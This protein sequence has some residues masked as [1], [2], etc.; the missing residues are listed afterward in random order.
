ML[1]DAK[2]MVRDWIESEQCSNYEKRC[3]LDDSLI[4]IGR[5][6]M[7]D[8]FGTIHFRRKKDPELSAN[9]HRESKTFHLATIFDDDLIRLRTLMTCL[10][11]DMMQTFCEKVGIPLKVEGPKKK[12]SDI[13]D[14]RQWR[15]SHLQYTVKEVFSEVSGFMT[16][17][18][19]VNFVTDQELEWLVSQA[20]IDDKVGDFTSKKRLHWKRS[21]RTARKL[22]ATLSLMS[23]DHDGKYQ[24]K[25][26]RSLSQE[27]TG[28]ENAG[29][30]EESQEEDIS[31]SDLGQQL[32]LWRR[33]RVDK[34]CRKP[35]R[36]AFKSVGLEECIVNKT[37]RERVYEVEI[38]RAAFLILM[39]DVYPV[40]EALEIN[41][42]T[43]SKYMRQCSVLDKGSLDLLFQICEVKDKSESYNRLD[44]CAKLTNMG[45]V[46]VAR[47]IYLDHE[48]S[49]SELARIAFVLN[50]CDQAKFKS[51]IGQLDLRPD[52]LPEC[53]GAYSKVDC[54]EVLMTWKEKIRPVPYHYRR[55][56]IDGL[57]AV[58]CSDLADEV[59][60]GLYRQE[61]PEEDAI[62]IICSRL[63]D[64]QIQ[65]LVR[66]LKL[67]PDDG[68]QDRKMST[69]M[70]VRWADKWM[71]K[72]DS[73]AISFKERRSV[74]DELVR[75][76]FYE[77]A[78]EIMILEFSK[79]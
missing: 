74:N 59:L 52:E 38:I 8:F 66:F 3:K 23:D 17:K 32:R 55:H 18:T 72:Y 13:I 27:G 1:F 58:G 46:D 76:G 73:S 78:H 37:P 9:L 43:T 16:N 51:L 26:E 34:S 15:D 11:E 31:S 60:R 39:R 24:P 68:E 20:T 12:S 63:D 4:K 19:K 7:T 48:M 54:L 30:H 65:N 29:S 25:F 41:K 14:L 2:S 5:H 28:K 62:K 35:L 77:L 56:I 79:F 45:Y 53:L 49:T 61:S 47:S 22:M 44:F 71:R 50:D 42:I 10:D 67:K 21:K 6:D 75:A 64:G 70:I 40:I 57:Q 36:S 33:K 69:N